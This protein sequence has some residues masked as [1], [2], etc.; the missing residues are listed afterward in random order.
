MRATPTCVSESAQTGT[1]M[2]ISKVP[3]AR[4]FAALMLAAFA[5]ACSPT[6]L[7]LPM[8]SAGH[9]PAHASGGAAPSAR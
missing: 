8:L 1:T 7:P 3:H 2:A 4:L 9:G 5:A 6:A